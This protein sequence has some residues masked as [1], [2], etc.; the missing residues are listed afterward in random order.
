[1][2]WVGVYYVSDNDAIQG[3]VELC[4]DKNQVYYK[5]WLNNEC[6]GHFA[7]TEGAAKCIEEKDRAE[8]ERFKQ[9]CE[10]R[11]AEVEAY[12]KRDELAQ[13]RQ[14][15]RDEIRAQLP[16]FARRYLK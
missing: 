14:D 13:L 9:Q 7:S 5:A 16:W 6:I 15:V 11:A 1:M 8:G 3:R 2:K 4:G 12:R 10:A